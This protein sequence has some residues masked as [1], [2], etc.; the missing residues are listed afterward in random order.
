MRLVGWC[1]TAAA[2]CACSGRGGPDATPAVG[3]IEFT[4]DHAELVAGFNWAKRQA[5]SYVFEGDPVG[6]WFEAALPGREAFCMRDVSHQVTGAL[7]LGLGEHTKNMIRRFAENISPSRDWCSYWEINRYNK[8]APV[9]YRNDEDFW[10]NLPANFDVVEASVRVYDWTGDVDYLDDPVLRNFYEHSLT[11]YVEAW[12]PDEDGIM[13]SPADNGIRGIPTY[14]EGRGPRA[15]T[16]ADLVA[17][18]YAA[19]EAYARLLSVRGDTAGAKEF[20]ARASSLRGWFNGRWWSPELER[21][22]TSIVEGDVFDTT[23]IPLLQILPLYYGIVAPGDRRERFIDN[24]RAGVLVEVNVY[25]AEAYYRHG[26]NE[27][28]FK[29]LMAQ[30]DAG[31][32]RREYPENP[33]TAIGTIVRYLMGV[34][35]KASEGVLETKPRL[36]GEMS[37]ARIQHV[38]LLGGEI[39]VYH[40]GSTETELE[41]EAGGTIRWRPVFPGAFDTL[42]VDG[43]PVGSTTRRVDGG[44]PESYVELEVV[45]GDTRTVGVGGW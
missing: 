36:P 22:Y 12:D 13:E 10:Y 35:P 30:L 5:L 2:L 17:A 38:P 29:R 33:F 3:V 34:D 7:V 6:K 21:F 16:G 18:Q 24:L 26:R 4:S 41:N 27:E 39:S 9:D 23:F 8:P 43:E 11:S 31:L 19:Y 20:G 40:T 15:S 28:G 44:L 32:D 45:S 14:W 1:L 37:W 42:L 25:L